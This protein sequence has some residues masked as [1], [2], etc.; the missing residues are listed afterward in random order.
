[1]KKDARTFCVWGS[2]GS[3]SMWFYVPS[4]YTDDDKLWAFGDTDGNEF[5]ILKGASNTLKN[6]ALRS[7]IIEMPNCCISCLLDCCIAR[8]SITSRWCRSNMRGSV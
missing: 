5:K 8:S 6:S 3:I 7:L 4:S 1:M 2:S